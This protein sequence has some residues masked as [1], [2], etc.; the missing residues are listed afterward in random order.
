MPLLC[1]CRILAGALGAASVYMTDGDSPSLHRM[2]DNVARNTTTLGTAPTHHDPA[3]LTVGVVHCKQLRW[4][5]QLNEF[6]HHCALPSNEGCFDVIMGSDIIYTEEILDPLF[7][8]VDFLLKRKISSHNCNKSLDD[9]YYDNV[10]RSGGGDV[11]NSSSSN[12]KEEERDRG[13]FVL[14]FARRNV[15]IDD[16]FA[17]A[18][19]HG[20]EWTSPEGGAEE[21]CFVFWR[22][23]RHGCS[24]VEPSR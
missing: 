22:G 21:G 1:L 7:E 23:G 13:I 10:D 12:S 4:G 6:K 17:T 3:T 20:F 8:T 5:Q 18:S 19:R 15:K 11:S 24:T 9:N 16:V 2:R 14:A